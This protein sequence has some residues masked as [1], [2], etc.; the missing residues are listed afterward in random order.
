MAAGFMQSSSR[1]LMMMW[2]ARRQCFT[3]SGAWMSPV[4]PGCDDSLSWPSGRWGQRQLLL[5]PLAHA[6]C[7]H[8]TSKAKARLSPAFLTRFR[9]AQSSNS[10]FF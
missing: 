6:S 3:Q 2:S 7:V 9:F 8:R 1:A 10:I 5:S 4:L